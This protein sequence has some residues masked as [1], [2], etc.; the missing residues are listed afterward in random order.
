MFGGADV[1]GSSGKRSY[2]TVLC[3]ISGTGGVSGV[4]VGVSRLPIY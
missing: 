2:D 1:V 3:S 4:K